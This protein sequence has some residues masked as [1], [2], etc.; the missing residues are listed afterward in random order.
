[1]RRDLRGCIGLYAVLSGCTTVALVN[2]P[3]DY[4]AMKSPSTVWL[5]AHNTAVLRVDNPSL[6]GD[7]IIGTTA[8][9]TTVVPLSSVVYMRARQFAPAPTA[10]L[11]M[12]AGGAAVATYVLFLKPHDASTL[13]C[14]C[15][16]PTSFPCC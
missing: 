12:L 6:H 8:A 1:M 11:V 13:P 9:H 7:T 4:F 3:R 15:Q 14:Y 16:D 10:G 5:V 2:S